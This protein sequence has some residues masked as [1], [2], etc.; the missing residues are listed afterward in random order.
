MR[1]ALVNGTDVVN[2]V[3]VADISAWDVPMGHTAVQ[4]SLAGPGWTYVSGTFYPPVE[5]PD[6]E[7]YKFK[8]HIRALLEESDATLGRV[9]EAVTLGITSSLAQ[10]VVSFIAYRRALRA[11]LSSTTV[12]TIPTK[13]AYPS[14]T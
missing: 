3:E 12:Q 2:V 5:A 7:L 8:M 4:T 14:G 13:P 1:Y 6:K 11:L 9:Q 10:D